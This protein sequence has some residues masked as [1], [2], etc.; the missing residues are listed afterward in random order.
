MT[1]LMEKARLFAEGERRHAEHV[2][3]FEGHKDGMPELLRERYKAAL[4]R[5]E[6][7]GRE[8]LDLEFWTVPGITP[9]PT[10]GEGR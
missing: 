3:F 8:M 5:S 1:T 6:E 9:A 7:A 2:R 10:E 4:E